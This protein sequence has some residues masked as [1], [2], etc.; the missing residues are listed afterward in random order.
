MA[1]VC[2][3][4]CVCL[5]FL[6]DPRKFYFGQGCLARD[7]IT[8]IDSNPRKDTL[9]TAGVPI[10]GGGHFQQRMILMAI[11]RAVVTRLPIPD[12]NTTQILASEDT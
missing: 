7:A 5:L 10:E 1:C 3:C 6:R 4:V 11:F 2:V 8:F 12:V 9:A